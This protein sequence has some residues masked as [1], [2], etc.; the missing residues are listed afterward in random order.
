MNQASVLRDKEGFT[1]PP[2]HMRDYPEPWKNADKSEDFLSTDIIDIV[3]T[4]SNISTSPLTT[5]TTST[6]TFP[7]V[8]FMATSWTNIY[9]L[10]LGC[11][12]E[13]PYEEREY[14]ATPGAGTGT[15]PSLPCIWWSMPPNW[16]QSK[17]E[18]SLCNMH[19]AQ[20][21]NTSEGNYEQESI[22]VH[23]QTN[24][25]DRALWSFHQYVLIRHCDR[26]EIVHHDQLNHLSS[27]TQLKEV[28]SIVQKSIQL[29]HMH[30]VINKSP[31]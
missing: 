2:Y 5:T 25:E 27:F 26:P 14:E 3:R 9:I 31:I 1:Y 13:H 6:N 15:D 23:T 10:H 29:N 4:L 16:E 28:V 8:L 17:P 11:Q 12:P 7:T 20:Q 19:T 21:R 24:W 18:D 30:S 22:V